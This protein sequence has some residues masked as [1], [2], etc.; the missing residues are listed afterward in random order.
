[1]SEN[2]LSSYIFKD[3]VFR[4]ML[5][6]SYVNARTDCVW[7][8]SWLPTVCCHITSC[9]SRY[10][11]YNYIQ[12]VQLGTKRTTTYKTLPQYNYMASKPGEEECIVVFWSSLN[13]NRQLHCNMECC[14]I[15]FWSSLYWNRQ[16]HRNIDYCIIVF[17]STLYWKSRL[18]CNMDDVKQSLVTLHAT[19]ITD[20]DT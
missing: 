8:C 15:V 12:N 11:T 2:A 18:H 17:W 1:M 7:K 5:V 19:Q 13:W 16:L 9:L 3:L 4:I 20:G 14:I 6:L 10:K